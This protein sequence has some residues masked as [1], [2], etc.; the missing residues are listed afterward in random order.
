MKCKSNKNDK[1]NGNYFFLLFNCF[2]LII[3]RKD[4][5]EF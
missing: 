3:R 4:F 1:T 2:D 5:Q